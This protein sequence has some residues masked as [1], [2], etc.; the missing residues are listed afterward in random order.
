MNPYYPIFLNLAGKKC[1]VIGGGRVAL[2]KVTTL[3]EY[4]AEITVISPRL[5]KGLREV[6]CEGKI[7]V[8]RR[9]YQV[10]DL[11]GAVYRRH[12]N[13]QPQR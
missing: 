2:R 10:G 4:G 5:C 13:G 9:A 6:D 8:R 11:E 12:C 3:L 1:V 7:Q